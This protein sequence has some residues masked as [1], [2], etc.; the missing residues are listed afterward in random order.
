MTVSYYPAIC[1]NPVL[2]HRLTLAEHSVWMAVCLYCANTVEEIA[3]L[4]ADSPDQ[5]QSV[6]DSLVTKGIISTEHVDLDVLMEEF[7]A[8]Q[9]TERGLSLVGEEVSV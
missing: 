3:Q 4:C 5:I 6:L 9:R 8:R 7:A 1:S 2:D